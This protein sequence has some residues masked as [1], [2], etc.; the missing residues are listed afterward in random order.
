MIL[1]FNK[2]LIIALLVFSISCTERGHKAFSFV[3]LCDTQLGFGSEGYENDIEKFK[4]AVVQINELNPDFVVICGDLV[5]TP[6]D[7]SFSDFKEI[8]GGF[9]MPCY[10]APGNHDV[11]NIPNDTILNYYRKTIGTDYYEFHHN[12]YSFIVTNTQLWQVNVSDESEKHDRW[13]KE[14]LNKQSIK[15]YPIVVIGHHPLYVETPK[16]KDSYKNLSLNKRQEL[17]T[18][19]LQNNVIAYLSGHAHKVIINNYENIQL[20]SGETT[21]KNR[22]KRPFGFRLWQVSSDTI[23]HHFVPL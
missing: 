4:R 22:D 10:N 16:E 8:I 14:T 18:L 13:F 19:F 5:N 6:N 2:Y 20:V 7:S 11:G 21:S 23:R 3:Q 9:K 12:G 15:K 1:Q 17:L